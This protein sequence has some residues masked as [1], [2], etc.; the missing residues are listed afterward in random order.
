MDVQ[1]GAI[2]GTYDALAAHAGVLDG[3]Q[4]IRYPSGRSGGVIRLVANI[5]GESESQSTLDGIIYLLDPVDPTS[6][7]PETHALKRQCVIHGKPY[8]STVA[9]AI[10]WMKM[11]SAT[12]ASSHKEFF[13]GDRFGNDVI[14]LIAHDALKSTMVEFAMAHFALLSQFK[15]RV[16]TGT[17]GALL[18]E[19]AWRNGWPQH[20]QW[21]TP[22][23]SGPLG[24]DGQIAELVLDGRCDRV[25]FFEDPHVAR[26]HEADIQ[27]LERSVCSASDTTICF[28][29]PAMATQW[30]LAATSYFA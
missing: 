23:R 16:A 18:N 27:L 19:L 26:Q 5:V 21:V 12:E 7:Y 8:V 2:A 28:N 22:Y 29:S 4:W 9:G 14:A 17:T 15:R 13:G 24:G 1:F 20:L 10:E 11:S 25:I 30:A 3:A 6:L